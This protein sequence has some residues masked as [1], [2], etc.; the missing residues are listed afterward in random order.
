M[1]CQKK[2]T[3]GWRSEKIKSRKYFILIEGYYW[4]LNVYFQKEKS[5]ID[6]DINFFENRIKLYEELLKQRT[7]KTD[8][9]KIWI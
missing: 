2:Q 4:L 5:L 8:G 1:L 3:C 7:I 9:V 6:A